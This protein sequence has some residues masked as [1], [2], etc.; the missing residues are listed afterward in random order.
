MKGAGLAIAVGALLLAVGSAP[1][2]DKA[3]TSLYFTDAY[4]TG[5]NSSYYEGSI[6][7]GKKACANDRKVTVFVTLGDQK[8]KVGSTRSQKIGNLGY[9]WVLDQN[10]PFQKG[11]YTAKAPETDKCKPAKASYG[12]SWRS[13]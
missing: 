12:V 11:T 8:Q 10:E 3:K 13:G 7:S 9:E 5:P 6:A 4:P 1:A 2:A